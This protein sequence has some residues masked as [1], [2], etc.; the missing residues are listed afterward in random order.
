EVIRQLGL[1][2][3]LVFGDGERPLRGGGGVAATEWCSWRGAT[4]QGVVHDENAQVLGG[5]AGHAGLF[6]TADAVARLVE[7][8]A[9]GRAGPG[10]LA[11]ADMWDLRHRVGTHVLGWDTMS[12]PVSSAGTRMSAPHTVGHLGFTGTSVWLD[13]SRGLVVVLL[14]NRVH[15]SREDGRIRSLRPAVHDAVVDALEG[16]MG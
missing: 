13:R 12:V 15:P 6:G 11:V 1:E 4:L 16:G 7:G 8:L 5:V 3:D 10:E 9:A 2:G 14:T